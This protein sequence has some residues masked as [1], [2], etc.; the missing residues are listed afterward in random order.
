MMEHQV[1]TP[2]SGMTGCVVMSRP[3]PSLDVENRWALMHVARWNVAS[4][5][6]PPVFGAQRLFSIAP[7]LPGCNHSCHAGSSCGVLAVEAQHDT[8]FIT[9]K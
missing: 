1:F 3:V 5:R 6:L 7:F 2:L 8:V 9:G 4:V